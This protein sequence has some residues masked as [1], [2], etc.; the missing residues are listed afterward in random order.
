MSDINEILSDA[1]SKA[2][3][4]D[5]YAFTGETME[6]N[7]HTLHRIIAIKDFLCHK[8]ILIEK[9]T[10][11][12]W[13]ES[14]NN[15]VQGVS[16]WVGCNAKVYGEAIVRCG[17]L[18]TENA[19]VYDKAIVADRA[20]ITGNARVYEESYIFDEA[21]VCNNAVIRGKAQVY[22]NCIIGGDVAVCDIVKVHGHASVYGTGVLHGDF[23]I[24]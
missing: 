5:N 2:D 4:W 9:G 7:G 23:N 18:V 13:I 22:G 10:I 12:G 3:R 11:G 6:V 16:A 17:A 24:H 19:V 14:E 21:L 20:F 15:L 8:D 1:T